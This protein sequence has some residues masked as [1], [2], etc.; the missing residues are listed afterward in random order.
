[1]DGF[2]KG[3]VCER[4]SAL[5][6]QKLTA[7]SYLSKYLQRMLSCLGMLS[8]NYMLLSP[9]EQKEQNLLSF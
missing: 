6:E 4:D 9:T 3:T 2:A 8:R 1:M 7:V 5:T